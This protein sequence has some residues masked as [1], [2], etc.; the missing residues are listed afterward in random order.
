MA[1]SVEEQLFQRFGRSYSKGTVL[2]REGDKGDEMYVIQSGRVQIS[3][4][5]RGIDRTLTVLEPGEFLGEMA[6]LNNKPRSATATLIEDSRLLV[7]DEKTFEAMIRGN[8]EIALR[9]IKKLSARLQEADDQIEN[10]LLKDTN[11]KVVHA[12]SRMAKGASEVPGG[13]LLRTNPESLAMRVG[14]ALE[15]V[16]EVLDK[17]RKANLLSE[18]PEGFVVKDAARLEKFLEYLEMREQFGDVV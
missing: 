13:L 16:N 8:S 15:K 18:T 2:F 3:M 4:N 14:L 10:L 9:M 1:A 5:I 17:L 6:L 12:L 11:S 7:I